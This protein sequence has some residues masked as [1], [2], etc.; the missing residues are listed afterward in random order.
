MRELFEA[1]WALAPF[2][3]GVGGFPRAREPG[4]ES[5]DLEVE[6]LDRKSFSDRCAL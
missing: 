4:S 2:R 1:V 5:L 6:E 3:V